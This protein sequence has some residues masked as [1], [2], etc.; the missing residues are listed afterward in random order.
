[1]CARTHAH[2]QIDED[3]LEVLKENLDIDIR[4][5][6]SDVGS[7]RPMKR[8]RKGAGALCSVLTNHQ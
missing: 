6:R 1:V 7:S 2:A 3:E 8:L 4:I 5:E